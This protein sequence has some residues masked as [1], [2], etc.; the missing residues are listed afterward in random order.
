MEFKQNKKKDID[1][2]ENY[3]EQIN[4]TKS[5]LAV[6]SEKFNIADASFS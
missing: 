1:V 5:S 4:S 6:H 3:V 2:Y